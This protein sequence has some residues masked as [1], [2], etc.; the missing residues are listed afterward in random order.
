M[1]LKTISYR[2]ILIFL[3]TILCRNIAPVPAYAGV[4]PV[5]KVFKESSACVQSLSF[6]EDGRYIVCGF[7]DTF[8]KSE[9]VKIWDLKTG[10]VSGSYG[11]NT[12]LKKANISPNGRYAL[13]CETFHGVALLD[14][15]SCQVLKRYERLPSHDAIAISGDNRYILIGGRDSE[16]ET[17]PL[18]LYDL[19]TGEQIREFEGDSHLD[20]INSVAFSPDNRYAASGSRDFT[21]KLWDVKTGMEIQ[22]L[23]GHSKYV[24]SIAFSPDGKY[25]LSGASDNSL[26]V[27]D[28][29]TGEEIRSFDMKFARND[30]PYSIT[31]SPN[32]KYVLS[33]GTFGPVI[34]WDFITGEKIHTLKTGSNSTGGIPVAFSPDGSFAA[35]GQSGETIKIWDLKKA[36]EIASLT[37]FDDGEWVAMT[38]EGYFNI[39]QNGAKH[40]KVKVGNSTYSI[41]N[42]FER[43]YY[44][45][46]LVQR[47]RGMDIKFDHDIRKGI[48]IPPKVKIT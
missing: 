13:L 16:N 34:L 31:F 2:I 1:R 6:S 30:C 20:Y 3:I 19:K 7:G 5:I 22:T 39:S 36:K 11:R 26:R 10:S 40:L 27:W 21:I 12:D 14:A 28:I 4:K 46:K 33:S 24:Q 38:P 42:F 18:W 17:Y 9:V 43:Y 41:N 47:L 48:E 23:E 37:T 29:N 44:P 45:T 25:L 35:T 8:R 32:G 15:G